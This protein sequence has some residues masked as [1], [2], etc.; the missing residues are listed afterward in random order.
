[1]PLLEKSGTILEIGSWI[2]QEACMQAAAWQRRG[3]SLEMHVNLSPRQLAADST[4]EE[5]RDSLFMSR[6]DPALLVSR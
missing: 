6:L 4:L 5:L 3:M 2:I 1:M